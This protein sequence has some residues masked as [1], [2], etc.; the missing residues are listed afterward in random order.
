MRLRGDGV[1][2]IHLVH[3]D[4]QEEDVY[5]EI[6]VTIQEDLPRHEGREPVRSVEENAIAMHDNTDCEDV[7]AE[8]SNIV[9]QQLEGGEDV[10]M[11]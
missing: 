11:N 4:A 2:M 9:R 10:V 3:A 1:K 8:K 5:A 7:G 6:E